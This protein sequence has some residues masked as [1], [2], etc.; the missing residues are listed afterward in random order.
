[1]R[2]FFYDLGIHAYIEYIWYVQASLYRLY[3]FVI[4]TM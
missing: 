4:K 1:M 2:V 3:L